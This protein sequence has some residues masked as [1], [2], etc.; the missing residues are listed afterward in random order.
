MSVIKQIDCYNL[1]EN[2]FKNDFLI[3]FEVFLYERVFHIKFFK[4][5]QIFVLFFTAFLLSLNSHAQLSTFTVVDYDV[6][7]E[8]VSDPKSPTHYPKLMKRYLN[9]DVSLTADEF[10]LLYYG[11]I[12]QDNY[13]PYSAAMEHNA[14][15]VYLQ[16]EEITP[17]DCDM[18]INYVNISLIDFPFNFH[19]LRMAI[20]AHHVKGNKEE[21]NKRMTM[22]NGIVDA[23]L[24]SGDGKS[25][26]TAFHVIY[27]PHE[28]EIVNILGYNAEYQTLNNVWDII[29]LSRNN[30]KIP[31][32]YFNVEEMLNIYREKSEKINSGRNSE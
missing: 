22:L 4:M 6:I 3:S 16:K 19:N 14:L 20:Y 26:R 8:A 5:K 25:L 13:E 31:A 10:R 24:S 11:H 27:T 28:Y 9:S 7:K 2:T 23:I 18:I 29:S 21:A 32:L 15:S 30:D 1:D 12:Y 17:V